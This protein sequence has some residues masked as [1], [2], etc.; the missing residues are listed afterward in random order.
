MKMY[1]GTSTAL[2]VGKEIRPAKATGKQTETRLQRRHKVFFTTNQES[3][4]TYARRASR[5]WGGEPIVLE[6]EP[7][8]LVK[9]LS[10][11]GPPLGPVYHSDGATVVRV[12][13][14]VVK[15]MPLRLDELSS[16]HEENLMAIVESAEHEKLLT[17]TALT[18][19]K[20]FRRSD[21]TET[22]TD[23]A[24]A[25][26][27]KAK[28]A[29]IPFPAVGKWLQK[30][31]GSVWVRQTNLN[32]GLDL[33]D[34]SRL[35]K[36]AYDMKREDVVEALFERRLWDLS[37]V[38]TPLRLDERSLDR[39]KSKAAKKAARERGAADLS[40]AAKKAAKTRKKPMDS[41]RKERAKTRKKR[42]RELGEGRD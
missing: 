38:R 16:D 37:M 7:F 18:A 27:A 10:K 24:Y 14:D 20:M 34:V 29:G 11:R 19:F 2:N 12:V 40:R 23:V 36:R 26:G 30:A 32:P 17:D 5:K 35:M 8:G 22:S 41:K 28:R 13:E 6:V 3:A 1:H 15:R 9:Q 31:Y 33:K 21:T 4:M 42:E 39:E 25:V